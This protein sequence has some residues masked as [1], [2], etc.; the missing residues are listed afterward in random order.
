V[1]EVKKSQQ[2][3]KRKEKDSSRI[4]GWNKTG[5]SSLLLAAW[6]SHG[7]RPI[8]LLPAG[9]QCKTGRPRA[10]GGEEG[11]EVWVLEKERKVESLVSQES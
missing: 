5:L 4:V 7:A 1:N 3:W 6:G 11:R 8:I 2:T 10:A 9:P